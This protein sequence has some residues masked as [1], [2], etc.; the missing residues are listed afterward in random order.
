MNHLHIHVFSRD[1]HSP[2]LKH[3]KHYLSFNSSF[4]VQL[5]E[6]PLEEGSARFRPGEWSKWDMKC[7][8]CGESFGQRFKRLK[9]HLEG[10]FE[11]WKRE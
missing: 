5:D 11:E 3:T 7:W 2:W 8:R 4:L 9:E 6:F 10:E 1:M